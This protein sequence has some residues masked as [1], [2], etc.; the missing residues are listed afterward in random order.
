MTPTKASCVEVNKNAYAEGEEIVVSYNINFNEVDPLI[1]GL[2]CIFPCNNDDACEGMTLSCGK[3]APDNCAKTDS[4]GEL[5]YTNAGSSQFPR[6]VTPFLQADGSTNR[7]F[8]AI[9]FRN[10]EDATAPVAQCCSEDFF[11]GV[12]QI[13]EK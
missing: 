1:D 2:I 3:P 7:C 9:V 5:V 4:T 13:C 11:V 12:E 10:N 8:K 6:P